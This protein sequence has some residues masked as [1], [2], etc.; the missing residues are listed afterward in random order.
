MTIYWLTQAIPLPITALLPVLLLPALGIS[1]VN[2]ICIEFLREACMIFILVSL[3]GYSLEKSGLFKRIAIK[4][5]LF[6]GCNHF[7][8]IDVFF[9]YYFV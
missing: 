7:R 1:K 5:M 3:M 6:V 4:W 9:Q 8:Y 2:P